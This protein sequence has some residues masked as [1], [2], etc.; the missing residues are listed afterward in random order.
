MWLAIA[1]SGKRGHPSSHYLEW[2]ER[3][4]SKCSQGSRAPYPELAEEHST[5]PLLRGLEPQTRQRL[6]KDWVLKA[7]RPP[8]DF[9]TPAA[10]GRAVRTLTPKAR[11]FRKQLDRK[12]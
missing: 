11:E 12:D 3:F 2:A 7:G 8:H 1:K 4:A 6:I 10:R 9:L 5:H